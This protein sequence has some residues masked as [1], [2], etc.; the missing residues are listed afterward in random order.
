MKQFMSQFTL[1]SFYAWLLIFIIF[2]FSLS[3]FRDMQEKICSAIYEAF[4]NCHISKMSEYLYLKSS[5]NC[6]KD[7]FSIFLP[8]TIISLSYKY[9]TLKHINYLKQHWLWVYWS[10]SV[11]HM[12]PTPLSIWKLLIDNWS[13][14]AFWRGLK[15]F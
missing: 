10:V 4:P 8:S 12:C 9:L 11:L 14:S 1:L 6:L 13:S 15:S 3:V 5:I 2:L 7:F